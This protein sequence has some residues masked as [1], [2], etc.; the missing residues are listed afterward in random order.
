MN[1]EPEPKAN[2]I[3]NITGTC[4]LVMDLTM[5]FNPPREQTPPLPG[6]ES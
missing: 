6:D 2:E 1:E 3:P 4:Q 5:I